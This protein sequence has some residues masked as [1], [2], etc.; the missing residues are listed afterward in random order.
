[1]DEEKKAVEIVQQMLKNDAFSQW[2]GIQVQAIRPGYCRLQMSVRDEMLN[3]FKIAHG[4]ITYALADSALAFA[5]NAQ[6]RQAVSIETSIAH[7]QPLKSGEIIMAE[8]TEEQ[9][10]Y[11]LARYRIEVRKTGEKELVALFRGTVYRKD[12]EWFMGEN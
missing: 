9:L 1:M 5:S 4:A 2:L 7:I 6:G 12:Q 3:G 11:R 8:A 10:G